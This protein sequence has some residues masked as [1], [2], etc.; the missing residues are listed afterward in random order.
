M[1]ERIVYEAVIF[2]ETPPLCFC[3]AVFGRFYF[4]Y[5]GFAEHFELLDGFAAVAFFA[6]VGH[7]R[8]MFE[9]DKFGR[10]PVEHQA[11]GNGV[12]RDRRHKKILIGQRKQMVGVFSAFHRNKG[13]FVKSRNGREHFVFGRL[14]AMQFHAY[15]LTCFLNAVNN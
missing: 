11:D 12:F 14:Y 4:Q 6:H 5:Y 2:V 8:Q 3:N 13:A 15:I 9:I 1:I 7:Y 10:F